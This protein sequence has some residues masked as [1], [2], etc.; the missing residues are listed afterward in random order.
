MEPDQTNP[1]QFDFSDRLFSL[2]SDDTSYQQHADFF[3]NLQTQERDYYEDLFTPDSDSQSLASDGTLDMDINEFSTPFHFDNMAHVLNAKTRANCASKSNNKPIFHSPSKNSIESTESGIFGDISFESPIHDSSQLGTE[4]PPLFSLLDSN[5]I[6]NLLLGNP[7]LP[8]PIKRE[9][10]TNVNEDTIACFNVQN[11]YDHIMAAE[12]FLK[13]NLSFLAIQEPF[14]S[15]HKVAESWKSFRMLELESARIKC[16]E[17]PYQVILYDS[18]K[19]GGKLLHNFKS[20]QY[21]RITSIAFQFK[22]QKI[23]FISIYAPT[24]IGGKNRDSQDSSSIA[25]TSSITEKIMK[26]WKALDA[27]IQIIL[28]GDLQET[29]SISNRDNLGEY[30]QPKST[31]GILNLVENSHVSIARKLSGTKEYITRLGHEGG[32]GIDHILVPNNEKMST[33]VTD[34]CVQRD[35]GAVYFPSDHSLV[36]CKFN[37]FGMNNNQSSHSKTKYDYKRI[38]SIKLKQSGKYGEI[39]E[40]DDTQ[41]KDCARFRNQKHIY[42]KLQ[43]LT[44]D[45]A[46]LTKAHIVDIEN[47]IQALYKS[48]WK[49]T[50]VQKCEGSKN[51]LVDISENQALNISYALQSFNQG[52]KHVMEKLKLVSTLNT[53]DK[54]GQTRGASG[55]TRDSKYL[56]TYRFKLKSDISSNPLWEKIVV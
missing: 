11:K 23:G 50:V 45:N 40:L 53:N 35:K 9:K 26:K 6:N 41:F 13:E 12:L 54:A 42:D 16:F 25:T 31:S 14:S 5:D 30:R 55:R 21:G 32:R 28:L 2:D 8:H 19:W 44:G 36:V 20:E 17:T 24:N 51:V 4:L 22:K 15:Q 52:V 39:L 7:I 18:W 34:A 38:C 33:W 49:N 10:Q 56:T 1:S 3:N 47:R 43:K 29:I 27:D 48:L 46:N 37:R